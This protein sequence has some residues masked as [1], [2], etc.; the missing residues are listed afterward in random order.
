MGSLTGFHAR[1]EGPQGPDPGLSQ[2]A[3][4]C[5]LL[6]SSFVS[7]R[8]TFELLA[9]EACVEPVTS[10]PCRLGAGTC[11]GVAVEATEKAGSYNLFNYK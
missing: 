8:V 4:A 10:L 5:C 2:P 11:A 1:K 6:S 3:L 7:I 9:V